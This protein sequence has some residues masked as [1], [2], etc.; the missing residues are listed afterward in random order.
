MEEPMLNELILNVNFS[1]FS[2]KPMHNT[3][4]GAGNLENTRAGS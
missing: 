2:I 1:C 4:S 3:Y